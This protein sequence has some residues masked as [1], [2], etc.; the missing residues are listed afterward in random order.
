MKLLALI[1]VVYVVGAMIAYWAVEVAS[2]HSKYCRHKWRYIPDTNQR[3]KVVFHHQDR[4]Q[5]QHWH[6]YKHRYLSMD[7]WITLHGYWRRCKHG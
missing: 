5:G 6:F 3:Q 7:G 2:G 4:F 1:I